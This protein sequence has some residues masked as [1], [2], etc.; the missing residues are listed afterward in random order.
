MKSTLTFFI[1]LTIVGCNGNNFIL[2]H[3][4]Y[5][6]EQ[7]SGILKDTSVTFHININGQDNTIVQ[8]INP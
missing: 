1:L 4:L 8:N 3:F 5:D 7:S 2:E 6:D